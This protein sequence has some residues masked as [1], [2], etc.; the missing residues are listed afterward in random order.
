MSLK[1]ERLHCVRKYNLDFHFDK[2]GEQCNN[3]VRMNKD[4]LSTVIMM[5]FNNT[6][7]ATPECTTYLLFQAIKT[8]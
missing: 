6:I 1:A 7:Q 8:C 2:A 5:A 3:L 4:F